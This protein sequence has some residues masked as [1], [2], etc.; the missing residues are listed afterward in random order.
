MLSNHLA[1]LAYSNYKMWQIYH[2]VIML[3]MEVQCYCTYTDSHGSSL[4]PPLDHTLSR[5]EGH[6]YSFSSIDS[7]LH[8]HH[9]M[10]E[11][12]HIYIHTYVRSM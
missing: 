6:L 9:I 8:A 3:L 5:D 12:L 1:T 11:H 2:L 7:L 4:L 10:M